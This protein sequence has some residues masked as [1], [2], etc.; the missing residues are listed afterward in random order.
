MANKYLD[1]QGLT[2]YDSNIKQK[3]SSD[4]TDVKNYVSEKEILLKSSIQDNK[5]AIEA[6]VNRAKN[7]EDE[8]NTSIAIEKDR[9]NAAETALGKRIDDEISNRMQ[10]DLD[11]NTNL[12]KLIDT[13]TD[14]ARDAEGKLDEKFT[15]IVEDLNKELN[16]SLDTQINETISTLRTEMTNRDNTLN[17]SLVTEVGD[18]KAADVTLQG[19]IAVVSGKIATEEAYRVNGDKQLQEQIDNHLNTYQDA[20]KE[21]SKSVSDAKNLINSHVS[22][23]NNPHKV[24]KEQLGLGNVDN[25]ADLDKPISTATKTELDSIKTQLSELDQFAD[26]LGES[27]VKNLGDQTI[28]GNL[29][30]AK[31]SSK[32]GGNLVV[33]GDLEVKGST[34]TVNQETVTVDDNFLIVNNKGVSGVQSG[35]AIKK[36]GSNN[37]YGIA[38]DPATNSVNLGDGIIKDGEFQFSS[39]SNNPILTRAQDATFTQ[40]HILS[41]D[42]TNKR[43]VDSG[44][45]KKDI[46]GI[47]SK[48]SKNESDIATLTS[49]ANTN[50]SDISNIKQKDTEQDNNISD[51][52]T[53]LTS[54]LDS[55]PTN[56]D[57]TPSLNTTNKEVVGAINELNTGLNNQISTYN[58][59]ILDYN[60]HIKDFESL[61]GKLDQYEP[62]ISVKNTA[63]NKDFYTGSPLM[64]GVASSGDASDTTVAKGTHTHPT[65]TSRAP[66]DHSSTTTNYG[67]GSTTK[68]G[69]VKVDDATSIT[70]EN[71]IQN[72]A[73]TSYVDKKIEEIK[74]AAE[75]PAQGLLEEIDRAKEAERVITANLNTEIKRATDAEDALGKRIDDLDSSAS[76]STSETVKTVE[77][78]DGKVTVTKQSIQIGMSQVTEL[79]GEF[80][81]VRSEFAEAD[82]GLAEAYTA[83]DNALKSDIDATQA[84]ISE[85]EQTVSTVKD[86]NSSIQEIQSSLDASNYTK[87]YVLGF[88]PKLNEA[89]N[90]TGYTPVFTNL[91]DGELA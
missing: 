19:N 78:V 62:L 50:T 84:R 88:E 60:K 82:K 83:A 71:P 23:E 42:N 72:K 58:N 81:S 26:Q 28:E 63:F 37:A 65:D 73:I 33:Q 36:D 61:E 41:W 75:N 13:E 91:D 54:K 7:K 74:T 9:A 45:S 43:A 80:T 90:V 10:A 70:S 64:D 14:R 22:D 68:Y 20:Y 12:T 38:Y 5:S 57:G 27:T 16:T 47:Q 25:T 24:T 46:E 86:L 31:D 30:I 39:N 59:H 21:L 55:K 69:H 66:I 2:K 6:E 49:K 34:K 3:I 44:F 40:D 11:I 87:K 89:G 76:L 85:V 56:S 15:H 79:S 29:I 52:N 1:L 8:L 35:I 67:V 17:T 18:R 51:I 53:K 77:Q 48:S 4:I 32:Q